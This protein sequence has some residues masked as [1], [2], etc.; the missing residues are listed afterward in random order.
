MNEQ[1]TATQDLPLG[2]YLSLGAA[3]IPPVFVR[4]SETEPLTTPGP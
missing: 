1:Q 4:V 2:G 3:G